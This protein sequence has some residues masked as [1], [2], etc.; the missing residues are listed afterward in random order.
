M[1]VVSIDV[2]LRAELGKSANRK[3]RALGRVPAVVYSSGSDPVSLSVDPVILERKIAASHAGINTLFDLEG[4]SQVAGR[5]VMVKELQRDPVRGT[6]LHADFHEIDMTQRLHLSV[7]IHL[8]GEAPGVSMGGVIE[9]TLR[10]VELACMPG[11][12]PDE[13]IANISALDLGDSLHVSDLSFP[14]SVE[15]LTDESL[16]VVS[17]ILPR[18]VAEPTEEEEGAEEGA[19][20]GSE[21]AAGDSSSEAEKAEESSD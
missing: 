2:E 8:D 13:V 4:E 16:S 17:V 21:D 9:H 18:A 10:E 11:S 14:E 1:G 6:V 5:T 12:I 15:V 19:E 20:E 3:L 7:P